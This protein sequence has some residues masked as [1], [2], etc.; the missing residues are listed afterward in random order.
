MCDNPAAFI[1]QARLTYDNYHS[2]P[3]AII[4]DPKLQGADNSAHLNSKIIFS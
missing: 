4:D 2:Q 1:Y 3:L